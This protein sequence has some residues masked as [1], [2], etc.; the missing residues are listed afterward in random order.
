M[1]CILI[2]A[3]KF[4]P[5]LF[6]LVNE[7]AAFQR[8]H[9]Q[10]YNL[11]QARVQILHLRRC[12]KRLDASPGVIV[13]AG[14]FTSSNLQQAGTRRRSTAPAL[15]TSVHRSS[16]YLLASSTCPIQPSTKSS[17][18]GVCQIPHPLPHPNPN[19]WLPAVSSE[20]AK[21]LRGSRSISCGQERPLR[22]LAGFWAAG[23]P[24]EFKK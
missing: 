21:R 17:T 10:N 20:T 2:L 6:F 7:Q 13:V 18:R 9:S 1:K 15:H 11:Q 22:S 5:H 24:K 3:N 12:K 14:W 4:Q 23:A 19:T 16:L 8:K